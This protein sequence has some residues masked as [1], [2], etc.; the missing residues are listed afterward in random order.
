MDTRPTEEKIEYLTSAIC[1]LLATLIE[2]FP[3][4]VGEEFNRDAFFT[5]LVKVNEDAH[6]LR[7]AISNPAGRIS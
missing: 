2:L 1:D 7:A 3:E 5:I 6:A 4:G